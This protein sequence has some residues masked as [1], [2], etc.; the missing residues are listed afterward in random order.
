M[1]YI[2][3]TWNDI[4]I[5]FPDEWKVIL[6]KEGYSQTADG[7]VDMISQMY[8][9]L[10]KYETEQ[11]YAEIAKRCH[12]YSRQA[13]GALARRIGIQPRSKGGANYKYGT[14]KKCVIDAWIIR[15]KELGYDSVRE[16]CISLYARCA[17]NYS[18]DR[19]CYEYIAS[20]FDVDVEIDGQV[21][22]KNMSYAVPWRAVTKHIH[23]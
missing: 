4:K 10:G 15:A 18:Y 17:H 8:Y 19:W 7:L 20:L 23:Y 2:M 9:G 12:P 21:M 11:S 13:I 16:A 3:R 14:Q 22:S 1:V 5:R 6:K